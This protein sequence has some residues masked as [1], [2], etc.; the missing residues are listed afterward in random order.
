MIYA[1]EFD[2]CQIWGMGGGVMVEWLNTSSITPNQL[3][4][5]LE[6]L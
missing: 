3:A 5:L 1:E 2:Q 6:W 4:A